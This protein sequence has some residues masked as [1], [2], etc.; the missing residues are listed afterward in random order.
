MWKFHFNKNIAV[1]IMVSI[2]SLTTIAYGASR[3]VIWD[4]FEYVNIGYENYFDMSDPLNAWYRLDGTNI[5]DGTITTLELADGSVTSDKIA[6]GT[7]TSADLEPGASLP[8]CSDGKI[9]TNSWGLEWIC[10]DNIW[11]GTVTWTGTSMLEGWPDAI[12]CWTWDIWTW[13]GNFLVLW[14]K[15]GND[16]TY[17]TPGWT[18]IINHTTQTIS[19]VYDN[20]MWDARCNWKALS[21]LEWEWKTFYFVWWSSSSS[22]TSTSVID[23]WPDIIKLSGAQWTSILRHSWDNTTGQH[24]YVS[25]YSNASWAANLYVRFNQD[26]T[27]FDIWNNVS[28]WDWFYENDINKSISQ[29]ESEWKTYNLVWGSSTSNT[30]TS[31]WKSVAWYVKS[32]GT[33]ISWKWFSVTKLSTGKYKIDFDTAFSWLPIVTLWEYTELWN[34]TITSLLSYNTTTSSSIEVNVL[35]TWWS[36]FSDADFSFIAV[37]PEWIWGAT[38]SASS[39]ES[40]NTE[41]T[42][43]FTTASHNGN[44]TGIWDANNGYR[45][46]YNFIQANGC[47]WDYHVCSDDEV[48]SWMTTSNVNPTESF[49][50]NAWAINGCNAW[51]DSSTESYGTKWNSWF[52][53]ES[54]STSAKVACCSTTESTTTVALKYPWCDSDD[55]TIWSY[56]IAACNVWA[57][58]AGITSASYGKYF[59][60]WN[61]H[62]SSFWDSVITGLVDSSSY[63]P[64]NYYTSSAFISLSGNMAMPYDWSTLRNDNLWWNT[65]NTVTARQG[66]CASWYHV[67]SWDEWNGLITAGWWWSDGT[68]MITALKLPNA[69]HRDMLW[70]NSTGFGRYWSSSPGTSSPNYATYIVFND[71]N[72]ITWAQNARALWFSVRCFKN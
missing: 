45:G 24:G 1:A 58:T 72:I 18:V 15:N 21:T 50:V 48:I 33:I 22:A 29:L 31:T 6:D 36:Q 4:L 64:W 38:S 14:S 68:A 17:R 41:L 13:D 43:K 57:S 19:G 61:N 47:T 26:G 32:D 11:G 39:T 16:V 55:I 44:F 8:T 12:Y 37:D 65:D 49:W 20:F 63:G 70:N 56:T 7:I 60:W 62:A 35:K 52:K 46:M 2:F 59:Q 51:S 30:T 10:S 23:G 28:G 34:S 40:S 69:W 25:W 54:C 3:G 27:Y 5:K 71:T 67:P 53:A 66:P 42:V 9:L